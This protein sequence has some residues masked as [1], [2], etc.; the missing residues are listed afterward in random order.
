MVIIWFLFPLT[1]VGGDLF[2]KVKKMDWLGTFLSLAMTVCFLVRPFCF[3]Y[4]P[5]LRVLSRM[6]RFPS[7]VEE[8]PLPG[9]A[10]LSLRCSS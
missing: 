7:P 3:F 9:T 1:H 8:Q 4:E 5:H 10:L 6:H 2:T